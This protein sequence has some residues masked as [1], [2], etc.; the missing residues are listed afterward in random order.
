VAFHRGT[1]WFE[2]RPGRLRLLAARFERR[3]PA[4]GHAVLDATFVHVAGLD[5]PRHH[6][7]EVVLRQRRRVRWFTTLVRTEV[8]YRDH[9]VR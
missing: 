7:A 2:R 1:L 6:S 4:G 5:L 8:E 3:L 9:V